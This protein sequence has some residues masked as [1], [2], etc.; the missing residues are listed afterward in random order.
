MSNFVSLIIGWNNITASFVD[1]GHTLEQVCAAINY[2]GIQATIV[3]KYNGT[4]YRYDYGVDSNYDVTIDVLSDELRIYCTSAGT[5]SREYSNYKFA[6]QPATTF[7]PLISITL[8][9]AVSTLL[10]GAFLFSCIINLIATFLINLGV[11][12]IVNSMVSVMVSVVL[13]STFKTTTL[14]G[15]T[16]S[17]IAALQTQ[18][19]LYAIVS[20]Q[21]SL[22]TTAYGIFNIVSIVSIFATYIGNL[23]SRWIVATTV[24]A[25]KQA[26]TEKAITTIFNIVSMVSTFVTYIGNFTSRWIITTTVSVLA[27]VIMEKAI[28]TIFNIASVVSVAAHFI[29]NI[30]SQWIIVT[31]VS[32]IGEVITQ[33]MLTTT[34]NMVSF[35]SVVATYITTFASQY[36]V[37]TIV[38]AIR[39][40]FVNLASLYHVYVT[41]A[42]QLS[43]IHNLIGNYII[44]TIVSIGIMQVTIYATFTFHTIVEIVY[45]MEGAFWFLI[46]CFMF[47]F[48]IG[49]LAF[50]LTNKKEKQI[51]FIEKVK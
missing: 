18:F 26:I 23:T 19:L 42:I 40:A 1:I 37:V 35:V 12:F 8:S 39:T 46:A 49:I 6:K 43:L 30:L 14:I 5:W 38:N 25:L 34:F 22:K 48:A 27:Q 45:T 41:V 36:L 15:I 9:I 17:Y 28:I 3:I 10:T 50:A 20:I 2:E 13:T 33:R 16:I 11:P 47:I 4:E 24:S 32:A 44:N 7:I 21:M 29:Q 31:T 51:G